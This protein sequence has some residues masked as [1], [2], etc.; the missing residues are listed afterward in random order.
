M[1]Q[2]SASLSH[3]KPTRRPVVPKAAH[4][5]AHGGLETKG[6]V[7]RA[8]RLD[9][10]AG[11]EQGGVASR[12]TVRV[13]QPTLTERQPHEPERNRR[14]DRADGCRCSIA[15]ST[16]SRRHSQRSRRKAGV[17]TAGRGS[18]PLPENDPS[19]F[20]FSIRLC[21]STARASTALARR[22]AR[23]TPLLTASHKYSRFG[24]VLRIRAPLNRYGFSSCRW[25]GGAGVWRV[26]L[27]I[28]QLGPDLLP[29]VGPQIAAGDGALGGD[30]DG[31]A[32]LDR[33]PG[34]TPIRDVLLAHPQQLGKLRLRP[35]GR[36]GPVN[37]FFHGSCSAICTNWFVSHYKPS[38]K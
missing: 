33:N 27:Q 6:G 8:R 34:R 38:Y 9:A 24:V 25:P 26:W 35:N 23:L 4:R 29:V 7:E 37:N 10:A 28:G 1:T 2:H 21:C 19:F 13:P 3:R 31:G 15:A 12:P 30:L 32:V 11:G 20:S 17:R 36:C 18:G 22:S 5:P 16:G 14:T